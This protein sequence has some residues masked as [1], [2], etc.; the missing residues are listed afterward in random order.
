MLT[1][2][3]N[4]KNDIM[5]HSNTVNDWSSFYAAVVQEKKAA[6]FSLNLEI[7]S[8]WNNYLHASLISA[9]MQLTDYDLVNWQDYISGSDN[10]STLLNSRKPNEGKVL[11]LFVIHSINQVFDFGSNRLNIHAYC[12]NNSSNPTF[13]TDDLSDQ[14]VLSPEDNTRIIENLKVV[15]K[16]RGQPQKTVWGD[17][18]I[19]V[20]LTH[21]NTI[22]QFCIISCKTSLRE[23]VYQ[24]IFWSM[25]SRMEGVGK[26]VFVTIDKG[27]SKGKSEIGNRKE[28]NDSKKSRDVLE[29][30][31]DRVYVL[32]NS[33]DVNRSQVVKDFSFLKRDLMN[34]AKDIT[35]TWVII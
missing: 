7:S 19:I 24:S 5:Q 25:H 18:D 16:L 11:E 33:T 20:A 2:I 22:Q 17:N 8:H 14:N 3:L 13:L 15:M 23:R 28:N 9:Y 30:T 27:D 1:T 21:N 34:W 29:S 10:V 4:F 35:G 31:M 32:R 12:A 26:H 6:N